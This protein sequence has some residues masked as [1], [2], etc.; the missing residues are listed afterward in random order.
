ALLQQLI[1]PKQ[2]PEDPTPP[3]SVA[4]GVEKPNLADVPVTHHAY[5]V[6]APFPRTPDPNPPRVWRASRPMGRGLGDEARGAGFQPRRPQTAPRILALDDGGFGFRQRADA[7]LWSLPA[8]GE[9]KPDWIV[10]KASRP[11]AQGDLW[12]EL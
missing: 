5:A 3:M 11:I 1:E 4:L 6:W 2:V 9:N 10:L 8:E 7:N 12:Q